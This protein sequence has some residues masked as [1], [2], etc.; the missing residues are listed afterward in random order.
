[1][2]S[3]LSC[4]LLALIVAPL[5]ADGASGREREKRIKAAFLYKFLS[6]QHMIWPAAVESS[7]KTIRIGILGTCP[8]PKDAFAKIEGT[9]LRG[10]KI[11]IAKYPAGTPAK[12][13]V[14]CD[15]LFISSSL[16]SRTP[17]ILKSLGKAPVL[18]VGESEGFV[19]GGGMV[20]FVIKDGRTRFELNRSAATRVGI[21]FRTSFLKA[22]IRVVEKEDAGKEGRDGR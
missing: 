2:R 17:E 22:A 19:D 1:L 8:F 18:T 12:T 4:I 15:L 14:S 5:P 20:R 7:R 16:K 6:R 10:R 13:L 21:R 3:V 9:E 11:V